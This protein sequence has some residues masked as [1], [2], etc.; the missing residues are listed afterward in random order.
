LH[1][2]SVQLPSPHELTALLWAQLVPHVPQLASVRMSVSQ[3]LLNESS[4]L[5]KPLLHVGSQVPASL[6]LTDAL[7]TLPHAT[8]HAPQLLTVRRSVSHIT[9][10]PLQSALPSSH[11][12][13]VHLPPVQ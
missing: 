1:I 6:Q 5:L 3:P 13:D 11:T 2:A 10:S 7:A 12:I 8:P 4:Q 9:L